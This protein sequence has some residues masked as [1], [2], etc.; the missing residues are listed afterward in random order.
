M[1]STREIIPV[2]PLLQITEEEVIG[3]VDPWIASPGETVDVKV[4]QTY[5]FTFNVSLAP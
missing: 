3:Y 2:R 1:A 5:K 4:S